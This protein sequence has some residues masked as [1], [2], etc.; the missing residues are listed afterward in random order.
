MPNFVPQI[1]INFQF[2]NRIYEFSREAHLA[3]TSLSIRLHKIIYPIPSGVSKVK[4]NKQGNSENCEKSFSSQFHMILKLRENSSYQ[5]DMMLTYCLFYDILK[6]SQMKA[7][8][9]TFFLDISIHTKNVSS[10]Y[11]GSL[12]GPSRALS[13]KFKRKIVVK[14]SLS[15]NVTSLSQIKR[16]KRLEK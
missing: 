11:V 1:S 7:C 14:P 8:S 3:F 6:D 15:G 13:K 12:S 5:R 16:N 10:A 4:S 9:V 2:T